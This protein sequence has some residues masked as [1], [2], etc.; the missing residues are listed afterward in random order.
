MS[1][2]KSRTIFAVLGWILVVAGAALFWFIPTIC[3]SD[4]PFYVPKDMVLDAVKT[5]WPLDFTN[6]VVIGAVALAG[7]ALIFTIFWIIN[8]ILAKKGGH[9]VG[10]FFALVTVLVI[11]IAVLMFFSNQVVVLIDKG[12]F[13]KRVLAIDGEFLFKIL[14]FVVFGLLGLGFIFILLYGICDFVSCIIE[15]TALKR[16]KKE[17]PVVEETPAEEPVVEEAPVE[18]IVV[19]EEPVEEVVIEEEEVVVEEE[20]ETNIR[21]VPEGSYIIR[22]KK[23]RE[24]LF[25]QACVNTG[26]YVV[27]DEV[28]F[29]NEEVEELDEVKIVKELHIK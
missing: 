13:F 16:T 6:I 8:A 4:I 24:E 20:P 19:E 27:F 14:V 28:D 7:L 17:E 18:E 15:G 26:D 25:Y 10:A 1:L 12:I 22:D 9:I 29:G 21:I 5:L 11:C 2:K 23:T 3:K